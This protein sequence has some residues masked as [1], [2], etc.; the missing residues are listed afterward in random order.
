M[1]RLSQFDVRWIPRSSDFV[2]MVLLATCLSVAA[3]NQSRISARETPTVRLIRKIQPAVLPIFIQGERAIGSGTASLIHSGGFML[4]NDHVTEGKPGVALLDGKRVPFRVIGRL[5]GKDLA[6]LQLRTDSKT[7]AIRLGRSSDLMAGEPTIAAGNPGGR[8]II[9]SQGIVSAPSIMDGANALMMT[10]FLSGRDEYIQ[11]DAASNPG[12]SG[13]PLVNALGEQI[14]IVSSGVLNEENI[15]Y[16]IPMDRVRRLF[17]HL[18]PIEVLSDFWTGIEIDTL[19]KKARIKSVKPGS[20]AAQ[21][22]LKK[23]D[24]IGSLEGADLRT[25]V[26]WILGLHGHKSGQE[27]KFKLAGK[28]KREVT[29]KLIPQPLPDVVSRKGKEAGLK[30]EVYHG[31]YKILP[32]FSQ[33]KPEQTGTTKELATESLVE[34]RS[35]Y[36]AL[37]FNGYLHIPKTGLYRISLGSDDGSK[38]FLNGAEFIDNDDNHPLQHLSRMVRLRAGLNAMRLEYF[39]YTGDAELEL[40]IEGGKFTEPTAIPAIWFLRD[41]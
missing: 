8:G 21:A 32:D 24:V 6:L 14:G 40:L 30:F 36:F 18:L 37:V 28:S 27:L 39:D 25:G 29:L 12:N 35:D 38:L 15:N 23:G 7:P 5:P 34:G 17:G 10:Y 16:A 19:T 9:F 4:S 20:P 41:K 33:L 11:F 13:G 2:F 1:T 22:G 31:K 3:A 26:D